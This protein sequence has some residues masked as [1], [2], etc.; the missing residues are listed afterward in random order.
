M[1]FFRAATILLFTVLATSVVQAQDLDLPHEPTPCLVPQSDTH[2][3]RTPVLRYLQTHDN[4]TL[5]FEEDACASA[6]QSVAILDKTFKG[7]YFKTAKSFELFTLT[8]EEGE[9]NT[10]LL[11]RFAFDTPQAAAKLHDAFKKHKTPAMATDAPLQIDISVHQTDAY[12]LL[13]PPDHFRDND[14][15]FR[16]ITASPAPVAKVAEREPAPPTPKPAETPKK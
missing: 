13:T 1:K 14:N 7:S 3:L 12:I 4:L 16:V 9:F 2:T 10:F 8:D 11:L 5:S 6:N 15:A